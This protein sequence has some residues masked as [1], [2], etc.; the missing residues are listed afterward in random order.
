MTKWKA[1]KPWIEN[2]RQQTKGAR[3]KIYTRRKLFQ[4]EDVFVYTGGERG[5]KTERENAAS[6]QEGLDIIT[7]V[8]LGQGLS[9]LIICMKNSLTPKVYLGEKL[10][11]SGHL[12]FFFPNPETFKRKIT[13]FPSLILSLSDRCKSHS[14]FGVNLEIF[15]PSVFNIKHVNKFMTSFRLHFFFFFLPALEKYLRKKKL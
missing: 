6:L 11:V 8:S 15:F 10:K 7:R 13:F 5:E 4:K 12:F 2:K 3:G 14:L 1:I 9:N